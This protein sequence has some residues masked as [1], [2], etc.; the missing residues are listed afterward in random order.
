MSANNRVPLDGAGANELMKGF[1]TR[2]IHSLPS[3]WDQ[4]FIDFRSVGT[5][6]ELSGRL[7]TVLGGAIEWTPP[8]DEAVFLM[9][10]RDAMYRPYEGVW[11]SLRYHLVHPG[12]YSVEYDWKNEPD[13]DHTPPPRF[14]AQEFDMYP[15]NEDDLPEWFERRLDEADAE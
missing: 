6:V 10:L 13:W 15:R 3:A 11:T 4:L 1:T 2:M 8:G 14:F 5:Y 7:I 12:R 9:K